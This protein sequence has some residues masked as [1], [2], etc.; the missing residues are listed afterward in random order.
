MIIHR[1]VAAICYWYGDLDICQPQE[2]SRLNIPSQQGCAAS[3]WRWSRCPQQCAPLS[4]CW[5]LSVAS[6]PSCEF[7][8]FFTEAHT[9]AERFTR[10]TD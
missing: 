5:T 3:H 10:P 2:R 8:V 7:S 4:P 6:P 9:S 1:T